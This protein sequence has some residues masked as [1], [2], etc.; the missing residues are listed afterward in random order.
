[1]GLSCVIASV[2]AFIFHDWI[3]PS[4]LT[5]ALSII[6][7]FII[8]RYKFKSNIKSGML[9]NHIGQSVEVVEISTNHIP[10]TL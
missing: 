1:M 7:C 6:G 4:L 2:S 3:T 9:V 8:N 5:G 10:C